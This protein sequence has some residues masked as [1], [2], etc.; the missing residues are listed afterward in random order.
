MKL[1]HFLT[2]SAMLVF[3]TAIFGN[4]ANPDLPKNKSKSID[5][6]LSISLDRNA[7][8]ARLIIP[9]NQLKALRAELEQLD[10]GSDA[11]TVASGGISDT[12]TIMGGLF[13]SLVIVFG[14]VWLTRPGTLTTKSGKAVAATVICCSTAAFATLVYANAGPPPEARSITG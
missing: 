7:K 4:I 12:Q 3:T 11:A 2:M 5:T 10:N 13:L 1:T 6:T 8:E 9:R 14:G